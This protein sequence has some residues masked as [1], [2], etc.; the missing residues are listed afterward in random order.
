MPSLANFL[1]N[2]NGLF[3]DKT[4]QWGEDMEF[5]QVLKKEHVEVPGLISTDVE[6]PWVLVFDLGI[7]FLRGVTQLCAE[8]PG[9][10]VCFLRKF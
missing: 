8:F 6:F 3:R 5:P 7:Q 10:Q 4:K 2:S 9:V 1:S